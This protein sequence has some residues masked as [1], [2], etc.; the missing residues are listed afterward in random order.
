MGS[1]EE[2][3]RSSQLAKKEGKGW[4]HELKR[5]FTVGKAEATHEG[6]KVGGRK[7]EFGIIAWAIIMNKPDEEIG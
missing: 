2:T 6:R 5:G 1:Y 4:E 3:R 7:L